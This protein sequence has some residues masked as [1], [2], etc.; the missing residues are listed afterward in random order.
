MA[1]GRLKDKKTRTKHRKNRD[2]V[3]KLAKARRV[4]AKTKKK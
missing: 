3:R 1:R 2:R 4:G